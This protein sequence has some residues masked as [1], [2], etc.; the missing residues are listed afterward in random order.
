MYILQYIELDRVKLMLQ[1]Q[2]E[3]TAS[4]SH[5]RG[6]PI[7]FRGLRRITPFCLLLAV[8]N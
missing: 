7:P 1:L 5:L 3:L 2:T 4:G 6:H 8:S